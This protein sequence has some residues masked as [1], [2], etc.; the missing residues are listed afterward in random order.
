[1]L[2]VRAK[3][4]SKARREL[5]RRSREEQRDPAQLGIY[6]QR[7]VTNAKLVRADL[8]AIRPSD[9]LMYRLKV[10][11]APFSYQGV[12]T[13]RYQPSALERLLGMTRQSIRHYVEV[14]IAPEPAIIVRGSNGLITDYFWLH[15]QVRP[16]YVWLLM[17]RSRGIEKIS[18][19]HHAA[20]IKVLQ[21]M[22][23]QQERLF[24]RK[25]GEDYM[26]PFHVLAGKYGVVW[27]ITKN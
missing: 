2:S 27:K 12:R 22:L 23:R 17:M 19:R 25:L 20:E 10:Y 6:P 1:M 26:H 18:H 14:G 13:L 24:Y 4:Q 7:K 5:I 21:G 11:G 15:H 8:N 9:R 16:L 3:S